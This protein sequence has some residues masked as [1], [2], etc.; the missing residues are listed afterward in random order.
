MI[1]DL[2]PDE[3]TATG[4]IRGEKDD[5]V[6]PD[7]VTE[8][9]VLSMANR[10]VPSYPTTITDLLLRLRFDYLESSGIAVDGFDREV[11]RTY[12]AASYRDSH[13]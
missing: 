8:L 6:I 9:T 3:Q 7:F 12:W 4:N 5:R 13:V 11:N 1:Y 2:L 10:L